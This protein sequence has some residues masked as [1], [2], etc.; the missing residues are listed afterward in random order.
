MIIMMM[1]RHHINNDDDDD[2]NVADDEGDAFIGDGGALCM[3]K[4]SCK[5]KLSPLVE[6]I[7][8]PIIFV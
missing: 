7:F 3:P 4:R 5:S 8:C 6:F 1:Y 2:D